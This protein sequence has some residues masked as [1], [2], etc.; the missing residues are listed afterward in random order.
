MYY[1][2]LLNQRPQT[3]FKF[4]LYDNFSSI[5]L[6]VLSLSLSHTHT[7]FSWCCFLLL[8]QGHQNEKCETHLNNFFCFRWKNKNRIQKIQFNT[9]F[10]LSCFCCNFFSQIFSVLFFVSWIYIL[11]IV[12]FFW[13]SV[14]ICSMFIFSYIYFFFMLL[15]CIKCGMKNIFMAWSY[16]CL[17]ALCIFLL[18]LLLYIFLLSYFF[19]SLLRSGFYAFF[20][21]FL[22]FVHHIPIQWKLRPFFNIVTPY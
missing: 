3:L 15:V 14:L 9:F 17:F 8:Q 6:H 5:F 16:L 13:F 12:L 20:Y 22:F 1:C 19:I 18:L 10:P 21:F 7:L 11:C 4:L 2:V